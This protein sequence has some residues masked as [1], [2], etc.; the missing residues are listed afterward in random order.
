MIRRP[1]R[2]TPL[3]SSA[4]SDVY[5]RQG[6]AR[7]AD[8]AHGKKIAPV[9]R[10]GGRDVPAQAADVSVSVETR[11]RHGLDTR[12]GKDPRAPEP[13]SL[14]DH[15]AELRQ[16]R[17]GREETGVAG[18]A[19]ESIGARVVDLAAHPVVAAALGGGKPVGGNASGFL[20][21]APHAA[22]SRGERVEESVFHAEG[23]EDAI[24][25]ETVES[26][27]GDSAHDLSQHLT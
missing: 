6:K 15:L 4:A 16:V 13:S 5:K 25:R 27:A 23:A 21:F 7:V 11:A 22:L 10:V 8:G 18:H 12:C 3:Y 14:E 24:L 17:R 26:L 20:R 19:A 9:L 2:S 1:P